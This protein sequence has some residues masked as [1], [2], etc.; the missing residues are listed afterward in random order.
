MKLQTNLSQ[1]I[2]HEISWFKA[3]NNQH[4]KINNNSI[5][6]FKIR[7][8]DSW[9]LEEQNWN[10][11]GSRLCDALQFFYNAC[12]S[13]WRRKWS[14]IAHDLTKIWIH[15]C[16]FK[17]GECFNLALFSSIPRVNL[18]MNS[19]RT[20]INQEKML[21]CEEFARKFWEKILRVLDLDLKMVLLNW[22]TVRV[23]AYIGC[24]NHSFNHA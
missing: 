23:L 4:N 12:T 10:S 22:K 21:G 11:C 2:L 16:C 8:F 20:R 5:I 1:S 6:D 13:D 14:S 17:L 15:H 18:L 19:S 9:P 3:Q 7:R 24:A